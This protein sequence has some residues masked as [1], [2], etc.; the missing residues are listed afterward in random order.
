MDVNKAKEILGEQFSFTFDVIN[1][2]IQDLKLDKNAS[3][4]DIGTGRGG[5]AI[6]LALNNYK[7]ITGEPADDKSEY[8]KKEWLESAKKIDV[9]HLITYKSFN[10]EEIPFED[11]S[12]DVVFILGSLHHVDNKKLA[13]KECSRVTKSNGI[14]CIFEPN[15]K[16]INFI[17]EKRFPKHPDAIDPRI[18]IR[19]LHLSVELKKLSFYDTYILKKII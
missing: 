13:L 9:D 15:R 18:F 8:A 3:I 12:F 14:I 6:T 4:L 2:V 17:R 7:V 10:A 1:P 5:M 19:D 16:A 11:K